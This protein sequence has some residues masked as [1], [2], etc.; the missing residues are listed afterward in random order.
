M[1]EIRDHVQT[2]FLTC[3]KIIFFCRHKNRIKN[4]TTVKPED[5]IIYSPKHEKRFST[6]ATYSHYHMCGTAE[7]KLFI[8]PH[9]QHTWGQFSSP[10]Q[11]RSQIW[12]VGHHLLSSVNQPTNSIITF[13][14][15]YSSGAAQVK[16]AE[17]SDKQVSFY[18][19]CNKKETQGWNSENH[20]Q[21]FK[22]S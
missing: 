5:A 10:H 18:F 4:T 17:A 3:W 20:G 6:C 13:G 1:S 19:F 8:C 15:F 7:L 9:M 22:N 16:F 14:Y 21:I 12:K 2:F 11:A